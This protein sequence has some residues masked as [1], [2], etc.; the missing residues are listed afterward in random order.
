MFSFL[1]RSPG[2]CHYLLFN[3]FLYTDRFFSKLFPTIAK[4]KISLFMASSF[5]RSE[6]KKNT[7]FQSLFF[8][9]TPHFE[10]EKT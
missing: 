7:C 6:K 8:F 3:Y 2:N 9:S 4:K 5:S 10:T 1:S